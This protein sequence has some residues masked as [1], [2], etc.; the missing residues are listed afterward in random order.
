MQSNLYFSEP[1]Q[2]TDNQIFITSCFFMKKVAKHLISKHT[3]VIKLLFII[4]KN[5]FIVHYN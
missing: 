4:K 3:I 5:A 1:I 2:N